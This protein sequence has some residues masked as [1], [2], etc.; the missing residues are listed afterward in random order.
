M[1]EDVMQQ[2]EV[3]SLREIAKNMGLKIGNLQDVDKLRAMISEAHEP[4]KAKAVTQGI[5]QKRREAQKKE[6]MKLVRVKITAHSPF[7]K[8][9]PAITIDAGNSTVGNVHRTIQLNEPWHVEQIILN[10]LKEK[11][12]R[13]KKEKADPTTRRKVYSNV[14][15]ASYNIEILPPLTEKELKELAATQLATGAID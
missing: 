10:V 3:E 12:Y 2:T 11:K 7:E 5:K 1:T 13:A 15:Y 14:S 9:L 4:V 8:Q 6:L